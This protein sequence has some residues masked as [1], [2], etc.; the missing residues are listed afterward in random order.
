MTRRIAIGGIIFNVEPV[1]HEI[2]K[3]YLD[4]WRQL[5]L[6]EKK[7]W[8]ELVA[9]HLLQQLNGHHTVTTL[10]HV[11]GIH[12]VLPETPLK[13]TR[14]PMNQGKRSYFT[15]LILNLW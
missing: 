3:A 15:N 1:G 8:E 4:A 7:Q 14:R 11:E 13:I 2:L 6:N 5:N 12:K 10:S 9:E